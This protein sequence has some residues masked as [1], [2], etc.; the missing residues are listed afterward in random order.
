[1]NQEK[2]DILQYGQG[3][4]HPGFSVDCVIFGFHANQLRVLLLKVKGDDLWALPGGF[5]FKDEDVEEAA[6]R[7]L[8]SR[9]GLD[10]IFLRQFH[11]FGKPDRSKTSF[12]AKLLKQRQIPY[13]ENHWFLQR[14]IT[15][16]FYA[17]VDYS[18]VTPRPDSNSEACEWWDLQQ[19]PA[20]MQDHSQILEKAL[21][22]L[23]LQLAYQ[24]IGYNLLA[25]KFTMPELQKLYETILGKQLDRRNFQR[26]I[27]AYDILE[28]LDERRSGVAH[29]A[30][31]LYRFNLEK[32]QQALEQGLEGGW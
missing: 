7:V 9:T 28:R 1:M 22:A 4:F 30:P 17:L 23:R 6:I 21:E 32:Y 13:D 15:L 24:P 18:S 2:E 31:Y 27:L 8:K 26:K 10:N 16:G 5:V 20:L 14:F 29:K 11:L 3:T 12:N 19:I 25:E